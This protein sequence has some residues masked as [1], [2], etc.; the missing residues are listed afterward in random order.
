MLFIFDDVVYFTR[1]IHLHKLVHVSHDLFLDKLIDHGL[2][3]L[4]NLIA[5]CRGNSSKQVGAN[6]VER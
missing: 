5:S 3:I 6:R 4:L 1:I 2:Q